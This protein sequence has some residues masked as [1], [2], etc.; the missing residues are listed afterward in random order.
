ME[1]LKAEIDAMTDDEAFITMRNVPDE[2]A[3][4]AG[5]SKDE[6]RHLLMKKLKPQH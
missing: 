1:D 6:V 5:C 3:T 2:M 4:N